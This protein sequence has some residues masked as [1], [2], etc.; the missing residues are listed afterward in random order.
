MFIFLAIIMLIFL[1]L[2][3]SIWRPEELKNI[4]SSGHFFPLINKP[5][6]ESKYSLTIIDNIYC[7]IPN[8]LE[9]CD[10]GILRQYISDHNEIFCVLYDT[11]VLMINIHA[12]NVMSAEKNISEIPD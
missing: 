11:T 9:M 2:L 10:V 3:K 6:H 4:L 12:S 5:T 7:N 8:P 1:Q